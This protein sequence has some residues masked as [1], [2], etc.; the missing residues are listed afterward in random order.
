MNCFRFCVAVVISTL[1]VSP[2]TTL[3]KKPKPA[4]QIKFATLAPEGSLWMKAMREIDDAVR[5]RT[6]NRVGFKFYPGGVQGDEKDVLRKI[7]NGQLHSGGFTGF[8]LGAVAPEVRVMELPF[9]FETLSELE[10]VRAQTNGYFEEAFD[11]KGYL[12]L[13]WVDVGFIYLF[14]NSEIRTPDDLQSIKM[15]IWSGDPLAEMFFKAFSISP[16]PLS[17]P[18]VLTSLQTG[19]INAVY[20]SPLACIALQWFTRVDYMTDVPITHALGGVLVSKKALRKMAPADVEVLI[21]VA[22]PVLRALTKNTRIQNTESF[23]ELRK[24]GVATVKAGLAARD[25]FFTGG[26]GAW[27]DGVGKLY[28]Q[29]LLDRITKSVESFTAH[30]GKGSSKKSY[31]SQAGW[32]ELSGLLRNRRCHHR[33]R[34]SP[35]ARGAP[36]PRRG[37]L[38]FSRTH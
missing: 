25:A 5:E 3:G 16:V 21:E 22:R 17:A 19:I 34:D 15:W 20:A 37:F 29:E 6:E 2:S 8:G 27:K 33:T 23:D 11:A 31:P 24:E 26:R 35:R 30:N 18:D 28:S 36:R 7:R 38:R 9:L 1:F 10:H 12:L 13:G 14:S 4:T 32:R